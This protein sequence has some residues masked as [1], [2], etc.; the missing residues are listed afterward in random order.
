MKSLILTLAITLAA[1]FATAAQSDIRS[2]DFK[3]FTYPAF[4]VSEET[5]N[6]TVKDGEFSQEK[7]MDGYVD[8]FYF[9]VFDVSYGDLN[10][11]RRDDAIILTVC[12]TGGT[13]Y[14][15]EGFIYS[16]RSGKPNLV[17]RIP[18]GDRAEGGL[19]KAWVEN[20]LLVVESNDPGLHGGACCPQVIVTSRYRVVG[21]R[22]VQSGK[23]SRRDVYPTQRVSFSKGA[24]SATLKV[25]LPFQEGK[26]FVLGAR[27]GQ[28]L[29][30]SVD[31]SDG[32]L[33]LLEGA[34]PEYGTNSLTAKLPKTG[35]YTIEV[36]NDS[37]ADLEITVRI[38]IQ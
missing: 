6:I 35:D 13:G 28:T 2:I 10:G 24:S 4:C 12:N 23:E 34:E 22:I 5:E 32:S 25:T 30:V 16:M 18:G 3:N 8:R 20:G 15:S 38:K 36:Q 26:R 17:A 21:D 11:D 31:K 29:T 14:F 33:R 19:R 27:A 37:D 1:T 9:K 7:E